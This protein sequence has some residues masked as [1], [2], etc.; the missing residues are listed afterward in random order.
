M[1]GL[2][3]LRL[4]IIDDQTT[5]RSI[6]RQLLKPLNIADIAEA[7]DGQEALDYLFV[8]KTE[9][10]PRDLI[11][12]DLHMKGMDGLEFIKRVRT[13]KSS[14]DPNI[15]ILVLTGD[16]ERLLREVGLQLGATRFLQKPISSDDLKTEIVRAVGFS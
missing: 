9:N 10:R 11:I 16:T 12:C 13:G 2:D 1:S 6:I 8:C 4:L 5:M 15:P 7:A 14:A 3:T